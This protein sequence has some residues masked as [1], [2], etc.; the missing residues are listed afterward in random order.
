MENMKLFEGMSMP[1]LSCRA[2]RTILLSA[3]ILGGVAAAGGA[4][5]ALWN[6]KP[7]RRARC[8]KRTGQILYRVGTAMRNVSCIMTE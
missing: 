8:V 6:S 7:M 2:R 3:C 4:G 1:S 5:V